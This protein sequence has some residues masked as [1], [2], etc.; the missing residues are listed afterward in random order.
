MLIRDAAMSERTIEQAAAHL[1]DAMKRAMSPGSANLLLVRYH[2]G[3]DPTP[4]Q[5]PADG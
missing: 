5:R 1:R 3:D 2:A 4:S